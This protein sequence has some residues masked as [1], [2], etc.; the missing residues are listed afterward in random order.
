MMAAGLGAAAAA[1]PQTTLPGLCRAARSQLG[2][3]IVIVMSDPIDT[4]AETRDNEAE[5]DLRYSG[6][7]VWSGRPNVSL[8]AEV[9][10]LASGR[11][12]DVGAGEG[13]DACYL[14]E[15]GWTVTASDISRQALGRIA[16]AADQQG[17]TVDVLHADANAENP[18][19]TGAFDLVSAHYASIPR[20]D[21]DRAVRNILAAV[22]PGGTLLVVSHDFSDAPADHH[23]HAH[24]DDPAGGATAG[25]LSDGGQGLSHNLEDYVRVE[26]F[27]AAITADS[28]WVID[29]Y[30]TRERP[31]GAA[32]HHIRD[33]VLRAHRV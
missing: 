21:D 1:R 24:A 22:A 29:V 14:A 8:V 12:L 7:P 13:A 30:E 20:T 5:W 3:R 11:A 9:A 19:Q 2:S 16:A 23:T 31:A 6:G 18:F 15:R 27:L 4:G 17:L 26:D 10:E 25:E 32:S 28:S 33:I